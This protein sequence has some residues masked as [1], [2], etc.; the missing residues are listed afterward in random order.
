MAYLLDTGFL[1]ALLNRTEQMHQAVVAAAQTIREPIILSVPAVTETAYLLLRD[2]GTAA[3][4]DFIESLATTDLI[5][6]SPVRGD[7][8]RAAEVIRQYADSRVDFVDAVIVAVAER[9]ST[10]R[11]LTLDHRHFRM[12]RPKHCEAFELLP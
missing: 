9:L 1:Y 11:V 10:S 6:E 2:V 4:G 5:L 12:F 8:T 3:V 7:Y